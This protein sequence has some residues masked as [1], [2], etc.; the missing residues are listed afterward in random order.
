M[1]TTSIGRRCG[2]AMYGAVLAD[3]FHR[4]MTKLRHLE[5]GRGLTTDVWG[6]IR[7][8]NRNNRELTLKPEEVLYLNT[9]KV[10]W[11]IS[12]KD[13]IRGLNGEFVSDDE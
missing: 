8:A 9:F 12:I 11:N 13:P 1:D 2:K 4:Y 6:K 5:E 10:L 7:R 3:S